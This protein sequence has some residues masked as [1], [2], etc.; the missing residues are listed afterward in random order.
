MRR[1]VPLSLFLFLA[2]LVYCVF[3]NVVS[4]VWYPWLS[5]GV[6]LYIASFLFF[7]RTPTSGGPSQRRFRFFRALATIGFFFILLL[8]LVALLD[9]A[10][11][12]LWTLIQGSSTN[13][14]HTILRYGGVAVLLGCFLLIYGMIRNPH[15]YRVRKE[16]IPLS[17]LPSALA[18]LK[19]VQISDIHAGTFTDP[20]GVAKGIEMIN[21]LE[22]D[23]VFF[24][25]DLVN[26][27]TLEVHPYE[28]I[29]SKIE[30]KIGVYSVLGNHDYGDYYAWKSHHD[31]HENFL[32][33][34]DVHARMGWKLLR[35]EHIIIGSDDSSL[36]IV[37]VEN[38]SASARFHR[39]G[40]LEKALQGLPEEMPAILLSHDPSHWR[41]QVLDFPQ[42]RLTLSGHT[43][44]MQFGIDWGGVFR[45]SPVQ[46]IYREWAGL[47]RQGSQFLYVNRGFGMLGYPGRVGILP[48][49]TLLKLSSDV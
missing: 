40:D 15:R 23:L 45:W 18:D 43:H 11:H 8:G 37:G 7:L 22:P 25:G 12:G 2:L 32:D 44:G 24:T 38:F 6:I 49:I 48:E 27:K 20:K 36:A 10:A 41:H 1:L 33:L 17:D 47:Y 42:V 16:I 26:R 39:Y 13:W 34:L 35:N 30:A 4:T 5:A 21:A 14:S 29:L 9:S 28:G 3:S 46:Y 31:K 19:I